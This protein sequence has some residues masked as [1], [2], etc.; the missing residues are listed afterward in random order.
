MG[1]KLFEKFRFLL[2]DIELR[3]WLIILILSSALITVE[4]VFLGLQKLSLFFFLLFFTPACGLLGYSYYRVIRYIFELL[5]G[6][7]SKEAAKFF[8]PRHFEIAPKIVV[9]GGGTGLSTLLRGIKRYSRFYDERNVTA[10][11]TVMDDGGSSG[12]IRAELHILP[13][14]DIRNCLVSL[15]NEETLMAELFKYRFEGSGELSGHS[16]GNLF[17]AALTN[18]TGDFERAVEESS[19][20]LAIKGTI[21]PAMSS[22]H[23]LMAELKNGSIAAGESEIGITQGKEIK[24][25]FLDPPGTAVNHKVIQAISEA[26]CIIFGPGSLFT[27][28][29]P[30]LLIPEIRAVLSESAALKIYICNIMTQPHETSGFTASDHIRTILEYLPKVKL[31]YCIINSQ[32]GS[33]ESLTRYALKESYPVVVDRDQLARLDT[34]IVLDELMEES[35]YL[36]HNF[37]KLARLII[38][39]VVNRIYE[40]K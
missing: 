19:K 11:V 16:F 36:R 20:I 10:V 5:R 1:K 38:N 17:I 28:V 4:I 18:V 14:G 13:P 33:E 29:I 30:N 15:A 32:R 8:P 40:G 39:L 31:D 21:L 3:R 27:S 9:I 25:V 24:R 26:D 6:F 23:T 22:S 12:R 34:D 35:D 2:P 7:D 37:K